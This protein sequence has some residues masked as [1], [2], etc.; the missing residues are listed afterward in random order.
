MASTALEVRV[1]EGREGAAAARVTRTLSQVVW[2][3]RDI[4]RIHLLHGTPATWVVADMA[5][6]DRDLVVRLAAR[7]GPAD[8]GM[9]DMLVPA[10]ALVDGA[11]TLQDQAS[12]PHLFAPATVVR[13]G[14]L[15]EPRDGVQSVALAM[16]NGASGEPV[17]LSHAVRANA[18]K[19]VRPFQESYGSVAGTLSALRDGRGRAAL[20][21]TVR[22]AT[23]EAVEGRVP[24]ALAEQLRQMWRHRVLL[25]GQVRRNSNGQALRIDVDLVERLP[26]D[27]EHRPST[28]ALLGAAA[29]WFEGMTVDDVMRQLRE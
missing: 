11:A 3:L 16:S 19:A 5:R 9:E 2:S 26:D 14:R 24:V 23:G 1:H 21:V 13:L 12:V 7:H 4:D 27:N 20:K 6:E 18:A 22:T 17:V 28:D 8:R 10:F 15:A 25:V 29:E